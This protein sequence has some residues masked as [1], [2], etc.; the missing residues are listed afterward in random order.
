VRPNSSND[1]I[2]ATFTNQIRKGIG[3]IRI[4]IQYRTCRSSPG[5]QPPDRRAMP[6]FAVA[7]LPLPFA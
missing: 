6:D 4:Q 7:F 1:R 3:L 5:D 2:V